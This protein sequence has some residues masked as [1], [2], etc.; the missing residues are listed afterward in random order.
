[1][2][3]NFLITGADGLIGTELLKIFSK[4]KN[5]KLTLIIKKKKLNIEIKKLIALNKVIFVNNVFN[6]SENWWKK[7]FKGIHTIIHL[8]WSVKDANYLTSNKNLECLNGTIKMALASRN[9]IKRFVGIGTCLEYKINNKPLS[10]YSQLEPSNL[11][12]ATKLS[13]LY[14]LKQI[15]CNTMIDFSWL[16]I[17]FVHSRS[18]HSQ[19]IIPYI[20][21][22]IEK[23]KKII[24]KSPNAVRDYIKVKKLAKIIMRISTKKKIKPIYNLCSGK[25]DTIKNIATEIAKKLNK[26]HLLRFNENNN[27]DII[28]GIKNY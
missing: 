19:K 3:K 6:K 10:I 28:S 27:K 26:E 5:Y 1:M 13:S 23:N 18:D 25:P 17:F 24:I 12:S 15:F 20:Y 8:A 11:Y 4:N 14:I 22:Q 2:K 21:S 7:K 16:R 9:I